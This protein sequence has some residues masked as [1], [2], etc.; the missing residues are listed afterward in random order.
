MISGSYRHGLVTPLLRL[1]GT[2]ISGTPSD[3]GSVPINRSVEVRA[4]SKGLLT[5]S[6]YHSTELADEVLEAI[7]SDPSMAEVV[8]AESDYLRV[9]LHLAAG[10]E[11]VTR[12]E[13]F[14]RRHLATRRWQDI[15]WRRRRRNGQTALAQRF[16]CKAERGLP[17]RRSISCFA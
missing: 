9:E 8:M 5:V 7:R 13:D 1:S 15:P 10:T 2:T 4:D 17:T 3:R 6:E 16:Y 11:M 14:M 12:L